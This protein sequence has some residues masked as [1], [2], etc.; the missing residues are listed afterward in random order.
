MDERRQVI[1]L[2]HV[3]SILQETPTLL[4]VPPVAGGA[5]CWN[6]YRLH[7][8]LSQMDSH[9]V[10]A[11]VISA[12]EPHQLPQ[13][14]AYPR[15]ARYHWV[16]LPS[17]ERRLSHALHQA[18]PYSMAVLRRTLGATTWLSYRYLRQVRR[19]WQ[20]HS[21]DL[22]IVDDA[23][24][25]LQYLSRFVPRE[26]LAF[27]F[28][29]QIGM[30][31]RY[32]N[33]CGLLITSNNN[34]VRYIEEVLPPS[35]P[36]PR[37][38]VVPNSLGPEFA[39][40]TPKEQILSGP[41]KTIIFVGRF[42]PVKGVRELVKA[43]QI[44]HERFPDTHLRIVG[45]SAYDPAHTDTLSEYEKEVR[46]LAATLPPGAVSF[47]G[48]VP[49]ERIP[50]EYLAADIAVFPSLCVEGFGMVALEAMRCGLPVIV[51]NRPGFTSLV[52]H[53]ENGLVVN[54]PENSKELAQ[55]IMYLLDTPQR[56]IDIAKMGL[57]TAIRYTPLV[58]ADA[59]VDAL[60]QNGIGNK[61]GLRN[62]G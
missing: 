43:F 49:Y 45:S 41:V 16:V 12:C 56:A 17:W 22:M 30:S 32:L 34:L 51:S 5:P 39:R 52:K 40:V 53:G 26:K 35:G 36:R 13:L 55:V 46:A 48:F 10:E 57:E 25:N 58:A 60:R 27:F 59:F 11:Q 37:I 15:Q 19:Y 20:A 50:H 54:E 18:S 29:G 21:F 2:L 42:V 47:A 9:T 38:A 6:V 7:E 8:A 23:P 3:C 24:Q 14:Q 33:R 31:R 62:S 4:P 61:T 1:R 44:V 28:R